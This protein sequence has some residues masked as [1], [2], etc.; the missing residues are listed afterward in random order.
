MTAAIRRSSEPS[1]SSFNSALIHAL[2][3]LYFALCAVLYAKY[4]PL[5]IDKYM[6]KINIKYHIRAGKGKNEINDCA[7]YGLSK[8]AMKLNNSED[9]PSTELD[10]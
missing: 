2:E 5:V 8:N 9:V 1:N 4:K 7:V 10:S 6:D 3:I